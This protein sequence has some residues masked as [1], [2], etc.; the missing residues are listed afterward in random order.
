VIDLD[1]ARAFVAGAGPEHE[2]SA[3]LAVVQAK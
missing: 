1:I 3:T 2:P